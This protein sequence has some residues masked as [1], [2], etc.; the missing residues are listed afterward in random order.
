MPSG[1]DHQ[2]TTRLNFAQQ[3]T[4]RPPLCVGPPSKIP[5]CGALEA[6][7]CTDVT[8]LVVSHNRERNM[9]GLQHP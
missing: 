8:P 2:S 9:T 6:K 7:K 5:T 3:S 4:K 1:I